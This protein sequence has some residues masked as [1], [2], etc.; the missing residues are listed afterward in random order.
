LLPGAP[1]DLRN[2]HQRRP[3]DHA[4]RDQERDFAKRLAL[5]QPANG[6]EIGNCI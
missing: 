1:Q 4:E 3:H 5:F 2:V 6:N